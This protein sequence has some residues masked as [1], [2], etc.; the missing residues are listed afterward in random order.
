MILYDLRVLLINFI[1]NTLL[2]IVNKKNEK[3]NRRRRRQIGESNITKQ[4]WLSTMENQH[5]LD[6]YW[7]L[8]QYFIDDILGFSVVKNR[9]NFTSFN[10]LNWIIHLSYD[11]YR[12]FY[13][14][15]QVKLLPSSN[16]QEFPWRRK[17]FNTL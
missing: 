9:L 13:I 15:L 14:M 4:F 5:F 12:E 16:L 8:E 1:H 2:H 11:I 3:K 10:Y 17:Y 6:S 7:K